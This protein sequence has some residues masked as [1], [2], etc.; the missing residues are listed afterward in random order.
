MKYNKIDIKNVFENL[1]LENIHENLNRE[2]R[3]H[4]KEVE[5]IL[6]EE[7]NKKYRTSNS[8]IEEN[9]LLKHC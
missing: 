3:F 5:Y 8:S 2:I 1:E 7:E 4:I 6:K 9:I